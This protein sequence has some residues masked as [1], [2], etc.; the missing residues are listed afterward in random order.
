MSHMMISLALCFTNA[1]ECLLHCQR[2][3]IH[4]Y[5]LKKI[6]DIKRSDLFHESGC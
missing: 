5:I 1:S 2:F 6:M 3:I 4:I